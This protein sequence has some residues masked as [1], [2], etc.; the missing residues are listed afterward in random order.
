MARA[1]VALA[2]WVVAAPALAEAPAAAT[3]TPLERCDAAPTPGSRCADVRRALGGLEVGARLPTCR[4]SD[5][6]VLADRIVVSLSVDGGD[7]VGVEVVRPDPGAPPP[8]AS[9]ASLSLYLRSDTPGA[10]T[11]AWQL[12]AA[13][14]LA[15]ALARGGGPL[16]AWL[17]PLG[18]GPAR[19][20]P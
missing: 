14:A 18:R 5:I 8:P 9:T 6:A 15:D 7:V 17:G 16:P 1:A 2:A 13:T 4:V 11:P 12:A 19:R 20:A 3:P 10:P